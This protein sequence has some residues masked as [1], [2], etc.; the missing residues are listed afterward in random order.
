VVEHI[1]HSYLGGIRVAKNNHSER[2]ANEKQ[3][4]TAIIEQAGG[5]VVVSR[6]ARELVA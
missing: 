4:E 2:V 1:S 6:E 3:V 5:R